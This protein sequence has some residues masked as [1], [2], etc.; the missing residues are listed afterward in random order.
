[1]TNRRLHISWH[2]AWLC[3]GLLSGTAFAAFMPAG[4]FSGAEWLVVGTLPLLPPLRHRTILMAGMA[5]AGGIILGMWRGASLQTDIA[6]YAP[7]YE[8]SVVI[9]GKV[10]EDT[11]LG[12]SGEQRLK[13]DRLSIGA[14]SLPG[15]VWVS[16]RAHADIK[17]G[18]EVTFSGVLNEGFGNLAG[19]MF[20][21]SLR[22]A[23]RPAPGDAAR[24]AR[25]WFAEH[26]RSSVPE[27]QASLGLGYLVGQR[28]ALPE[29]LVR[30]LQLLGLTHVVVASGYNLTILVRLTRQLLVRVSKYLA[31]AA[32]AILIGAFVLITGLS[33][34]MSRAGLVAG[35]SLA[36]WYYGRTIHPFVLLP[37]SAAITVMIN[38]LYIWGDLGWYLSF[39]A[40]GGVI[41]L[42]PLLHH[43]FWGGKQVGIFKRI[44]IETSAAQLLTMPI[45]AYSFGQFAP[46]ALPA[47]LLILPLIPLAMLLTFVAGMGA[48][49]APALAGLAGWPASMVLHYMTS[50]VGWLAGLPFASGE[51]DFGIG[52][53]I[54]S[55]AIILVVMIWL[56][57]ATK[58]Q[59]AKDSIIE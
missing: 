39:A 59:F 17:R 18:D 33:P 50:I 15:Q 37:L 28:S 53:L 8:R 54:A 55:Y 19:T 52:A 34:P 22:D 44:L 38:P 3:C 11:S 1:M 24:A 46:L 36:A 47:N 7:Y 31:T 29:D 58:H 25:D 6:A 32:A 21:A 4:Q 23:R 2:I 48:V 27:P 40:F 16:T 49:I 13:L 30:N 56:W 42:A 10:A 51:I 20:R 5:F 14:T 57:R 12:P 26:V 43:F 41:V 9:T 45:I 35:L